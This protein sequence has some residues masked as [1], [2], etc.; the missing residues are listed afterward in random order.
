[1]YATQVYI[2]G[3]TVNILPVCHQLIM[4]YVYL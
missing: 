3:V 1:M 4:Y 2:K